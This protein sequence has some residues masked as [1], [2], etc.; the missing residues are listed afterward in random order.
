VNDSRPPAEVVPEVA[1]LIT[2]LEAI[3]RTE[4]ALCKDAV[5]RNPAVAEGLALAGCRASS[6]SREQ[7]RVLGGG[8]PGLPRS[9]V[10]HVL[11]GHAPREPGR[12]AFELADADAQA[13]VDHALAAHLMSARLGRPGTCTLG[14]AAA[15]RLAEVRLH[16]AV[17][18]E[19][20][21]RGQ[22][23]VGEPDA[24]PAEIVAL[25]EAAFRLVSA[26][27]GRAREL[28]TRSGP[29]DAPTVL[30]AAGGAAPVAREAASALTE[31]GSPTA[32]VE[33]ALI[34]P[35]PDDALRAALGGAETIVL[36]EDPNHPD[37]LDTLQAVV[38]AGATGARG[39]IA[40][41]ATPEQLLGRLAIRLGTEAHVPPERVAATELVVLSDRAWARSLASCF[42]TAAGRPGS[43]RTGTRET[44]PWGLSFMLSGLDLPARS[45][46]VAARADGPSVQATLD[47]VGGDA[48]VLVLSDGG[49][50]DLIT[51]LGEACRAA[52]HRSGARLFQISDGDAADVA[53]AIVDAVRNGA[54]E[55]SPSILEAPLPPSEVAFRS[56]GADLPP[57]L[58]NTEGLPDRSAGLLRRFV[59]GGPRPLGPPDPGTRIA[60]ID[61]LVAALRA[62]SG[63]DAA[64]E[65]LG[66]AVVLPLYLDAQTAVRAP[67]RARFTALAERLREGLDD[68][69]LLERLQSDAGRDPASLSA[70]LG[71][72]ASMIDA[73][74][75]AAAVGTVRG[76]DPLSAERRARVQ[77]ARDVLDGWLTTSATAPYTAVLVAP[78][79]GLELP[80]VPGGWTEH[81][82]PMAAAVG[83][84]DGLALR[85]IPVVRA[86]RTATLELDDAY[87]D[88]LH[89][90]ALE[91]LSWESFTRDELALLS[92][93]TAVVPGSHVRGGGESDLAA[94]MRSGRPVGAVI[95]DETNP[96]EGATEGATTRDSLGWIA[97]AYREGLV[98][99]IALTRPAHA[100]EG[101]HRLARATRPWA[102]VVSTERQAP[103]DLSSVRAEVDLAGR[104]AP[105][106]AYD[107]DAGES[108]AER[109]SLEGNPQIDQR[110]PVVQLDCRDEDGT[111][112][113]LDIAVTH[114][115]ALALQPAFAD[116]FLAIPTTGWA[117]DQVPVAEYVASM[118]PSEPQRTLPFVWTI[119]AA[120]V[121]GRA[122]VS[123][124][125]AL[126]CLDRMR[127]WRLL[128][129]LAGYDNVHAHRAAAEARSDALATA[130]QAAEE[131][132]RAH[133]AALDQ[134]RAET[135]RESMERLAAALMDLDG[136]LV[137]APAPPAPPPPP[138][139]VP[140][141]TATS[142]TQTAEAVV[143]VAP[144]PLIGA[145]PWVDSPMCTTCN[146]CTNLNGLL[147]AYDGDK[148]AFLAD[149]SAGTF[150]ELVRAA[151]L[152]PADCIHPGKPRS[153]DSTATP[154]MI[155]RAAPYL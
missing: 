57:L 73:T 47:L 91:R 31:A 17:I 132:E 69:L 12:A 89:R 84:F 151:E 46:L 96:D 35:L 56:G 74:L 98:V 133:D 58:P 38:P 88:L 135:A 79:A 26:R 8:A 2:G 11:G 106:L 67:A 43:R 130:G 124:D 49:A 15:G 116:H 75:L 21:P 63:D 103:G 122:L 123:R 80:L 104:S 66:R 134:A 154:E 40:D 147:F 120:G 152:C 100:S 30:V 138:T 64:P 82:E 9:C 112:T 94:L 19:L 7:A 146:E 139:T 93:V 22:D 115:H 72:P 86:A 51:Q 148:Q 85:A 42:V 149:A 83:L 99:Q 119:D 137:G 128:Q 39:R 102:L 32:V 65:V 143:A 101:M 62:R 59:Q 153:G 141:A 97:A 129:E 127:A 52:L 27:T 107:P 109:L 121:L 87:D 110:W 92:G 70:S 90:E 136:P 53:A 4:R 54:G 36:V 60:A 5:T 23:F 44:V 144:A 145:D 48:D 25:A 1:E 118:V 28:C 29:A 77:S 20:E 105:L 37:W 142:E 24:G 33:V 14:R 76:S 125:V 108:W 61:P 34:H 111:E 155:E 113:V 150:A 3:E 117:A 140:T 10:H 55:V 13:A 6:I 16:A 95:L 50:F 45:I 41:G 78:G 68:L 81:P 71:L 126:A 114:A 131:L 18:E